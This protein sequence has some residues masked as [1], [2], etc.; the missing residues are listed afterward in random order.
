LQEDTYTGVCP[1]GQVAIG[2][3]GGF[4]PQFVQDITGGIG[5][6]CGASAPTWP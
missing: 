5:V 1:T 6:I 4:N 2:V 3:Y